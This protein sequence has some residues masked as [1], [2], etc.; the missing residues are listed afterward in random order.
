MKHLLNVCAHDLGGSGGKMFVGAFDGCKIAMERVFAYPFGTICTGADYYWDIPMVVDHVLHG[1]RKANAAHSAI[2]AF[3]STGFGNVFVL[4]DRNGRFFAPSFASYHRRMQNVEK[5]LYNRISKKDLHM[6]TGAEINVNQ[7]IMMLN[8]YHLNHDAYLL[9]QAA[10]IALHVDALKYFLCGELTSERTSAS[11]TG[12]YSI[13]NHDWDEALANA[14][15]I[16][17]D[18]LPPIADPCTISG[19]LNQNCADFTGCR[20]LKL[21]NAPQH[22][23]AAA[24]L[25]LPCVDP[26]PAFLILGTFALCGIETNAPIINDY[27]FASAMGNEANP[28]CK[29]KLLRSTRAMWYLDRCLQSKQYGDYSY[30]EAVELAAAEEAFQFIIDLNDRAWFTEDVDMPQ[31][32]ARYLQADGQGCVDRFSQILRCIF[33]SIA[34][35]VWRSLLQL[36]SATQ[37]E[38]KQLY[39]VNGGARNALIMQT[40]ADLSGKTVWA[41]NYHASA[42]GVVLSELNVLG[43]VNTL[44]EIREVALNSSDLNGYIANPCIYR[45]KAEQML[46][47][48]DEKEHC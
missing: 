23:T 44:N 14:V 31:Q 38:I 30:S 48:L 18:Q 2:K 46:N 27:T 43:E 10:H 45:E 16:S 26:N 35:F 25:A 37:M 19:S 12:L 9:E 28:F 8:A 47:K 15:R 13:Q 39:A 17:M 42:M 32:I 11:V 7:T 21:V 34:L 6:K 22:D 24:C 4:L 5:D 29:N 40:I 41:G 33:D 20:D 1:L 3:A 36:E